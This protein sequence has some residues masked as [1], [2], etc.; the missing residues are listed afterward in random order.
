MPNIGTY[1]STNNPFKHMETIKGWNQLFTFDITK[2]TF[3]KYLK[4]LHKPLD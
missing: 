3:Q 4:R 1:D 2:N